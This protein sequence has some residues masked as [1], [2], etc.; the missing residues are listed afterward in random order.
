MDGLAAGASTFCFAVLAIMG[1]WIFRH[2]SIYHV[3]PASAID[4]ALV[5]VAL[6]GACSQ[7]RGA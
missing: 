2:E 7:A 6:A 4:L 3:L 1:Y 5:A